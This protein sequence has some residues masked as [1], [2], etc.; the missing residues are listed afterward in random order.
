MANLDKLFLLKKLWL[1]KFLLKKLLLNWLPEIYPDTPVEN[2]L[3]IISSMFAELYDRI[4]KLSDT[5]SPGSVFFELPTDADMPVEDK[6]LEWFAG[7]AK[8]V[9]GEE[10]SHEHITDLLDG[11]EVKEHPGHLPPEPEHGFFEL[12]TDADKEVESEQKRQYMDWFAGW[13]NLVLSEEWDHEHKREILK[14]IFPLYR[15]RGTLEGLS[16]YLRIYAGGSITILDDHPSLQIGDI[17]SSIVG[18][19]MVIGGFP[20]DIPAMVVGSIS[21]LDSD[22]IIDGFPPYFFVVRA[23]VSESGPAA[24]R[25]KR[26]TITRILDMEKPAH[27]WYRLTVT[28]PTFKLHDDFLQAVA[29]LGHNTII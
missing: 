10:W 21:Q 13:V 6:H 18:V 28:G 19:N 3:G 27:T 11:K 26:K 5:V 8:R 1:K 16:E 25:E 20:P 23:A 9:L 22:S 7:W 2:L 12:P 17:Y 14:K 15:K 29:T 4:D 24:L